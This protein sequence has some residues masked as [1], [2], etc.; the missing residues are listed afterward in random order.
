MTEQCR[1]IEKTSLV[2]FM[3]GWPPK[4]L[5]GLQCD[6]LRCAI[7]KGALHAEPFCEKSSRELG[8]W[9]F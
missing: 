5:V 3:R 7:G 4:S 8:Y 1:V 9:E 2:T 6:L